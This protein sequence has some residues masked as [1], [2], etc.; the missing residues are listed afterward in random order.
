MVDVVGAGWVAR[1]SS[2]AAAWWRAGR[3]AGV[4]LI[5]HAALLVVAVV[6]VARGMEKEISNLRMGS[7]ALR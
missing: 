7:A 3:S 5:V 4:A 1:A 6:V 2:P